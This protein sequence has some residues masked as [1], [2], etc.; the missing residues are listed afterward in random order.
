LRIKW[1]ANVRRH[2]HLA[3]HPAAREQS[4]VQSGDNVR[5]RQANHEA[6]FGRIV[7]KDVRNRLSQLTERDL[8]NP[9]RKLR[10]N[11][12]EG[13]SNRQVAHLFL[14]DQALQLQRQPGDNRL[15]RN[16]YSSPI[17][18]LAVSL[19]DRGLCAAGG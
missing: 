17:C 8:H 1:A 15:Q 7:I 16:L 14:P 3:L 18:M 2:L 19:G 5:Q 9:V 12:L 13:N 4:R 10:E 11:L 6:I